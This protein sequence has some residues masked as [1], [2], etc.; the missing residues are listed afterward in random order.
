MIAPSTFAGEVAC[1]D[2]IKLKTTLT[3]RPDGLF[4]LRSIDRTEPQRRNRA[5]TSLGSW[6]E[7]PDPAELVLKS[8]LEPPQYFAHLPDHRLKWLRQRSRP[9]HALLPDELRLLPLVDDFSES[10]SMRGMV[11]YLAEAGR[12]KECT[13]GRTWP[14]AAQGDNLALARAY[15]AKPAIVGEPLFATI[16]AHFAQRP[17]P[18]GKGNEEVVIVDR[19]DGI[20]GVRDCSGP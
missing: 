14:I 18:D 7:S 4:L 16:E 5:I 17:K 8:E 9:W 6:E 15:A 13:S 1:A 12:F 10:F 20:E 19:H 3:L 11:V 2:C